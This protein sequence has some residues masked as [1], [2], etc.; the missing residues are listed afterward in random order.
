MLSRLLR[1]KVV[2]AR[3]VRTRLHDLV[4]DLAAGD[5]PPVT[6]LVL[7]GER[8]GEFQ[9]VPWGAVQVTEG[10]SGGLRV[11]GLDATEAVTKDDLARRVLLG[12]DVLD[13]LV[14]DV[15]DR[16]TI[17]AN[18]LWLEQEGGRLWLRGAD[19]SPWAV[20]RRLA[21]GRLGGGNNRHLL[22]WKYIEFLRG[23][24]DAAREGGDYHRVI[25]QLAPPEIAQLADA[26]PYLH[27][28]EL[29]TLLPDPLAADAL[30]AMSAERQLQVF[31]ALPEDQG[32]R[33]L[34]LMAPDGAADLIGRLLPDRAQ[35]LL[36]RL[37]REQAER[38]ADL[39][40]YPEDTAGGIMANDVVT[41]PRHLTA[42]EARRA[43]RDRIRVP[44]F[45]Y[46]LYVVEDEASSRLAGVLSLRDLL[47][48]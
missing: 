20:V 11:A 45:I 29:L 1:G 33:L 34:A 37:P 18:D 30:E 17:R 8:R 5:Y 15:A 35:R 46:Y 23:D 6:H 31:E 12:E 22:D 2:G 10:W 14:I 3:R 9:L 42:A 21:R 43:V 24:P 40:R 47:L 44:D 19:V 26:L 39:L 36:N 16:Q 48:A 28:A 25:A 38:V 27:A 7:S 13:A 4:V 32:T 41:V